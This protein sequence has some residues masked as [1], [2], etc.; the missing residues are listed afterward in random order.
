[1]CHFQLLTSLL[2]LFRFTYIPGLCE[3]TFEHLSCLY[4]SI[5]EALGIHTPVPVLCAE[6][7]TPILKEVRWHPGVDA[8][9]GF[10]GAKEDHTCI[11]PAM[12]VVGDHDESYSVIENAFR[13]YEIGGLA[14]VLIL[15]PLHPAL[16][17]LV[18]CVE[19]TCNR[20]S[21]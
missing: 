20:Y 16:P 4:K 3:K 14:R 7:E 17:R 18:V 10:C 8:L 11:R 1:M 13:D 9:I 19:P 21:Q 6:D 12:I 5:K 15:N 2:C